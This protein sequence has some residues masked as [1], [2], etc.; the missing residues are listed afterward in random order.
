MKVRFTTVGLFAA[1]LSLPAAG[2]GQGPVP[3]SAS[4][5]SVDAL[6]ADARLQEAAWAARAVGDTA[7]A[8]AILGRL[9][10]LLR[11]DPVDARP[12]SMDEQGVSYTF[13]L[14]HDEGVR[15][16]F[17]VDG[18]DIFCPGCGAAREVAVYRID[19][20][21][22]LDLTPMTVLRSLVHDGDTLQGSSMY[23][24]VDTRVPSEAGAVK[25]DRL[26]LLDAI[27]GNSDRHARN[28]LVREEG[29]AV[30]IDHNRAFE[31]QPTTRPKTCW[32]A[33]VD[34]LAAPG[35]L[36]PPFDRYR[37]LPADSLAATVADVLEP[38]M[39]DRFVAMRD[40]VVDR[41]R[42]RASDPARKLPRKDCPWEQ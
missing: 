40:R 33:E 25:P 28:W 14:I 3:P 6:L 42:R 2:S 10:G 13:G 35:D 7:R 15:A 20:L 23:F 30:A 22:G 31:Y 29:S 32:E 41:I 16:L 8:E 36:G 1:L 11:S 5:P 12:R 26:R 17:K 19:R 37:T 21:L 27:V 38:G 34:S 4:G 18:S 9:A 24:V 39:V